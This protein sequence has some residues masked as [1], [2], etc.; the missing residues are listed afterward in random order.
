M[1]KEDIKRA[2]LIGVYT[3]GTVPLVY[4]SFVNMVLKPKVIEAIQKV[5]KMF[6]LNVERYY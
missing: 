5:V 3:E 2:V 6:L 4:N 1:T